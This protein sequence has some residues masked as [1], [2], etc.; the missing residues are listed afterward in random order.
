MRIP[1][2]PFTLAILFAPEST[3]G[4]RGVHLRLPPVLRALAFAP[5]EWRF[6]R[7]VLTAGAL[8]LVTMAAGAFA[9]TQNWRGYD[10]QYAEFRAHGADIGEQG[11]LLTVLD[12]DSLGWNP[13]HPYWH[14]AEFAMIDRG[15]FTPLMFTT[16]G[17]HVIQIR[18]PLGRIA[19][20]TASQGSPPDIDEL[21]DLA[22]GR[23]ARDKD[24]IDLSPYLTAFQCSFDQAIVIFGRGRHSRVPA[25]LRL[26]AVRSFYAVYDIV[27]DA[28][29]NTR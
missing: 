22:A 18:P 26:R 21:D 28:R 25:M 2:L 19:A 5:V 8:S 13:D 1:P 9:L 24:L 23:R 3:I 27:P 6:T 29:C 10:A 20:A 7:Y 16:A 17:Q 15:V 12:G 4:G 14:M 11:R